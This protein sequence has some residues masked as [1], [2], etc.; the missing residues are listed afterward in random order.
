VLRG[1]VDRVDVC[2]TGETGEALG[3]II[4]YK[5]SARELDPVLLHYGLELQL[6]AYLGALTQ[7]EG[8]ED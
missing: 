1:R 4:D 6:L 8:L 7:S 5:S 3:V 2:R